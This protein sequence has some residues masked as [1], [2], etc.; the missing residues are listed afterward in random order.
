MNDQKE[1]L[2]VQEKQLK[3]YRTHGGAILGP[4][5]SSVSF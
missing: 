3:E 5:T 1:T 4:W 2:D